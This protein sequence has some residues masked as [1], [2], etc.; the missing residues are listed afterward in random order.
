MNDHVIICNG[1]N[2]SGSTWSYLIVKELLSD[3]DFVDL[4]YLEG[5]ELARI[6]QQENGKPI[7]LKTHYY[8]EKLREY[9]HLKLIY[10]HRDMRG[11]YVSLMKKNEAAFEQVHGYDF[12]ERAAQD[13]TA[14][15]QAGEMLKVPYEG[16]IYSTAEEVNR[17]ADYLDI[18]ISEEKAG[19]IAQEYSIENNI[20]RI[21]ES[22]KGFISK[23]KIVLNKLGILN[24]VKNESTLLHVNHIT[25][26]RDNNWSTVLTDTQVDQ[27]VR[28]YTDWMKS[29]GYLNAS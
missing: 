13:Y 26:A 8:N 2:R 28:K 10:T 23:L 24:N 20:E 7:L 1:I 25:D 9:P 16:I 27:I 22:R 15:I 19:A 11:I 14:W 12:L 6:D 21:R 18:P 5:K 17:I 4:G 29:N 3:Q